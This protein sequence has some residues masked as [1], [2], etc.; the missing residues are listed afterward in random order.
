[1]ITATF[2]GTLVGL[3]SGYFG[4]WID[5]LLMRLVDVLSSIPWLVVVIVG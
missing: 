5:N 2:I 4:G 1:M 3:V